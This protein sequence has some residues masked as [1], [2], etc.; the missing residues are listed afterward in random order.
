V[1]LE[2]NYL[3]SSKGHYYIE[4]R[5]N[6]QTIKSKSLTSDDLIKLMPIETWKAW[7]PRKNKSGEIIGVDWKA[8]K[9]HIIDQIGSKH[10]DDEET[11]SMVALYKE[12]VDYINHEPWVIKESVGSKAFRERYVVHEPELGKKMPLRLV[13]KDQGICKKC[14]L[15]S[16]MDLIV[17]ETA[18]WMY[19]LNEGY[20][21]FDCDRSMKAAKYWMA[22]TDP[23][24]EPVPLLMKG[25][26][27]YCY[28]RADFNYIPGIKESDHPIIGKVFRS[29]RNVAA[30]KA[31]I[32]SIFVHTSDISQSL[33]MYDPDG[34]RGKSKLM[35]AIERCVGDAVGSCGSPRDDD[36]FFT[37]NFDKKRVGIIPDATC[38]DF[39]QGQHFKM[40]TG[41]DFVM[42]NNKYGKKYNARLSCK[43][44][45]SSNVKPRLNG[46]LCDT[47][48]VIFYEP[49]PLPKE[50]Q[51][52]NFDDV[53]YENRDVIFSHCIDVFR[54]LT[55]N[56]K[57]TI[58]VDTDQLDNVINENTADEETFF[59]EYFK[60]DKDC[61]TSNRT[62][63]NCIDRHFGNTWPGRKKFKSDL[64]VYM[65]RKHKIRPD[66]FKGDGNKSV[67][68]YVGFG[69]E[70]GWGFLSCGRDIQNNLETIKAQLE[71]HK[72]KV[73]MIEAEIRQK[74]KGRF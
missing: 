23:I 56:G 57:N 70:S 5:R 39:M 11:D 64:D 62:V 46:K 6:K 45:I 53:I 41:G 22:R 48:R 33:L 7:F 16:V 15:E 47:R 12:L 19:K 36:D 20:S 67:Y 18:D 69:L 3:G 72:K 68:G 71:Y 21:Q 24:P 58:P 51:I 73:E 2:L 13:D 63:Y 35:K 50:Q 44:I 42:I 37:S 66:T 27:G 31:F 59:N 26:P 43:F 25:E 1:D 30:V 4:S 65:A 40:M 8:A 74:N 38:L 17:N 10:Y 61:R 34:Q 29:K 28:N 49:L 9:S 52:L 55:D 60:I 54:E 32:G 14:E